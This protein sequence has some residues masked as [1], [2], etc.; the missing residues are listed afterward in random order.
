[1]TRVKRVSRCRGICRV[2]WDEVLTQSMRPLGDLTMWEMVGK[3]SVSEVTTSGRA[4][5]ICHAVR[6]EVKISPTSADS[7]A[8]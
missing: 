8:P 5:S 7:H 4:L 2:A 6:T 3:S 1:M